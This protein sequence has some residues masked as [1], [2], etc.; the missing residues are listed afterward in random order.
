MSTGGIRTYSAD[1]DLVLRRR[2]EV[3][4]KALVLFLKNGFERTTTREIAK[5]CGISTGTLYHYIGAKEDI[6]FLISDYVLSWAKTLSEEV[7]AGLDAP[8]VAEN[9]RQ[10]VRKYLEVVAIGQDVVVFWYQEA[11]N[12]QLEALERV[13]EVE[14]LLVKMFEQLLIEGCKRGEF[15]IT[16][17][18]LAAHDI[19]VLCDM[20]AFRRWSLRDQYTLDQYI[21]RQTELILNMVL[22][23]IDN[24]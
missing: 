21:E 5:A 12:L 20:W 10:I 8:D 17:T 18:T 16:D 9:L 6:L 23:Q 3:A 1:E 7:R 4:E 24:V 2:N 15:G 13:F 22:C 11:R 14:S 19:V